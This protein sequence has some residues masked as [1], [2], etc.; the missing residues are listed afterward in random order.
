VGSV[1]GGYGPAGSD[2]A[3]SRAAAG[4]T[5]QGATIAQVATPTRSLFDTAARLTLVLAAVFA[6][7]SLGNLVVPGAYARETPSWTAQGIGQDWVDL[8]VV[9]PVL[10]FSALLARRGSRRAGLMLGG[11]VGYTAYSLVLYSLAV[12]FNA[13]FLVYSAALGLSFYALVS[14]VIACHRDDPRTWSSLPALERAA[15]G[16][17]I[18]IGVAFYILWLAEV[19]PAVA[20]GRSPASLAD[21]GLITNPVQ[22]L[23]IGIVLPAFILGGIALIRRRRLG[24]WLVPMMLAFAA[25]MDIAL[26]GMDLSMAARDVPGGGQR[27]PIFAGMAVVSAG[28]FW[29]MIRRVGQAPRSAGNDL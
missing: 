1:S 2:A 6:A 8:L 7:A 21:V 29:G 12:H 27:I 20:S 25:L 28:M 23:D 26:V 9:V 14:V 17:S 19:V 16:F 18:F 3:P 24:Y 10:L 11:A 5:R 22:V 15:G 13:L 4:S